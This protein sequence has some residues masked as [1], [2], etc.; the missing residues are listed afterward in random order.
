V[1]PDAWNV[2]LVT[3]GAFATED[4]L[5]RSVAAVRGGAR[6]VVLRGVDVRPT[7]DRGVR[8]LLDALENAGADV[9]VHGLPCHDAI[10]AA[11]VHLSQAQV[12]VARALRG[13]LPPHRT[14]GVSCHSAREV[15]VAENAG[16]DYV[17]VGPVFDTP[18]K[19]A[20]GSPLGLAALSTI[21]ARARVPV[22]GIGGIDANTAAAVVRAGAV[23]VA[24]IRAILEAPSP[25]DAA[26]AIAAEVCAA[27]PYKSEG[28]GGRDRSRRVG[29][30]A[31]R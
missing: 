16:A 31:I 22:I 26:H 10:E 21:C 5:H 6:A 2:V 19:R 15:A 24:V 25:A 4:L 27:R 11:G 29:R 13:T 14:L 30:G 3:G 7:A 17:F 23:G 1:K 20:F 8:S 9:I 18:S 28:E 12:S